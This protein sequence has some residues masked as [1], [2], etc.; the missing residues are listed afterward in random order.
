MRHT[1][2]KLLVRMWKRMHFWQAQES[3]TALQWMFRG[4]VLFFWLLVVTKLMGQRQL[5]RMTL[6]DFIS[7]ITM[8]GLLSGPLF[9]PKVAL[10]G[11]LVNLT[12]LGFLNI[13]LSFLSLK[14]AK[15]RRIVQDEPIIL[16][17]NGQ[18]LEK[19]MAKTRFNLDD[20]LTQ[21]RLASVSNISDVEFAVLESNGQISV[22]LKSQGRP[23]TPA[24]LKIETTYEGM[25]SV[26]IEDGNIIEDNLSKNNLTTSWLLCE[27]ESQGI[28]NPKS[29]VA[30]ILDTKGKLYISNK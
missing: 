2:G 11:A 14:N 27:L 12:L 17:Q 29:V 23:V 9:L 5:A 28:N 18:I 7:S 25:S 8:G 13:L 10:K 6:F 20:L 22:I 24:D 3:L 15:L 1:N 4:L 26:L 16:M 19:M 21:L 30:A